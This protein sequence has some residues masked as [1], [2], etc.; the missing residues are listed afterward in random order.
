M[1]KVL[2]IILIIFLIIVLLI[3][4]VGVYFYQFYVFKTFRV[5]ISNDVQDLPIEC[6]SDEECF[7]MFTGTSEELKDTRE[8]IELAPDFIQEKILEISEEAAYCESTCKVRR[9]YGD[10]TGEK[11]ESCEPG[12][13]EI[14]L[15]IRGREALQILNLI[16]KNPEIREL[17]GL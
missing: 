9:I 2:K 13:K 11:I 6:E 10:L 8:I 1:G 17:I 15:E 5:C 3:A 4:A 7:D 14:I 16:R 12:D